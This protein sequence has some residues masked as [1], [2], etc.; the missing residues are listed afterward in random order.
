MGFFKKA[1]DTAAN[2]VLRVV[3]APH[4]ARQAIGR[5]ERDNYAYGDSAKA[6]RKADKAARRN[7]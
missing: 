2:T 4:S 7:R 1:G 6:V 3:D 5:R